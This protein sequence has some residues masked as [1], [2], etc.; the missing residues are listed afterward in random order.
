MGKAKPNSRRKR[1]ICP[2]AERHRA[3]ATVDVIWSA[4]L[5]AWLC[6]GDGQQG[7]PACGHAVILSGSGRHER[8]EP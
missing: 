1:G 4:E 6:C 7:I 3:N 8:I 5:G 2:S